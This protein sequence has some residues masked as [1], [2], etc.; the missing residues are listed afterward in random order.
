MKK[1]A[2]VFWKEH[3]AVVKCIAGFLLL[4]SLYCL[5]VL[6]TPLGIPCLFYKLTGLCCPGCGISRFFMHL[7]KLEFFQA[8][9]QNLAMAVLL[10]LWLIIGAIE[11]FFNPKALAKDRRLP[12]FLVWGSVVLLLIFG[13]LRNLPGFAWLLPGGLL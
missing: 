11:F 5:L 13:V 12:Q 10:P 8:V 2:L 9:S 1:K 7:V 4:G 6:L 3:P